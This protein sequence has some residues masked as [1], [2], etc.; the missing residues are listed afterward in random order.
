M[1]GHSDGLISARNGETLLPVGKYCSRTTYTKWKSHRTCSL[2]LTSSTDWICRCNVASCPAIS[3]I[4]SK[5]DNPQKS[6]ENFVQ[7]SISP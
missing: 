1:R 2:A 5:E 6:T 7:A 4:H 3:I